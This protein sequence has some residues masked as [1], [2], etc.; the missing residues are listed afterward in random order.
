[1]SD[2]I[3][4]IKGLMDDIDVYLFTGCATDGHVERGEMGFG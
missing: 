2:M 1:M 4:R 3:A